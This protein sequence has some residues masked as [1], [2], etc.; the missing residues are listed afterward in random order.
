M[1]HRPSVSTLWPTTSSADWTSDK[2]AHDF[3]NVGVLCP[4]EAM[5]NLELPDWQR[6]IDQALRRLDPLSH[7]GHVYSAC[8][9]LIRV[10]GLSAAIGELCELR[11]TV[12]GVTSSLGLTEVIALQG[13]DLLMS[14][15][16][17]I[18]NLSSR[19]QV[20]A[21]QRRLTVPVGE[22]LLGRVLDGLGAPIDDGDPLIDEGDALIDE[23]PA[24]LKRRSTGRDPRA[25]RPTQSAPPSAM[26]RQ[27]I[28]RPLIT[29]IRAID[30][31]LSCGQGQRIAIFSPSGTGKSSLIAALARQCRAD[32][33][34]LALVGERGREV[35]DF[36]REQLG[37]SCM[38]RCVVFASTSDRPALER[39]KC[40]QTATTVAEQF[41]SQGK[42]VLLLVDSITRLARAQREL[43]LFQ[44]ESA[45]N[46][47]FPPSVYATLPALL[48]RSGQSEAGAIS[49]FYTVLTED[50]DGRDRLAEEV[51]SIVDG[52][53]VLTRTLADDGHFPAIDVLRS[54]SRLMPKLVSQRHAELAQQLRAMIA[55]LASIELLVQ[56]GEYRSGSDALADRALSMRSAIENFLRQ[57]SLI[58]TAALNTRTS[59]SGKLAGPAERAESEEIN[60][61]SILSMLERLLSR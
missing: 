8:G 58:E 17:P 44:G 1:G 15:L 18:S 38:Q 14:G 47:G 5:S 52:H 61:R 48:E 2:Q 55:K 34:V 28:T 32:V 35:G 21:L 56:V 23:G 11:L 4:P 60:L 39:I 36:V 25:Y 10:R 26:R 41:R 19:V 50:D 54:V 53:I 33:I 57:P 16:T 59:D 42:H 22:H 30:G 45:A 13:P 20:I 51:R 40:A 12:D 49:A 6:S 9:E 3:D 43:A 24:S 46:D 7:T 27:P 37:A 31:L 29:G